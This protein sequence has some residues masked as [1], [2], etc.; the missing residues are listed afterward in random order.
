MD[1]QTFEVKR[2]Y[3]DPAYRRKGVASAIIT[4]L[5]RDAA[6]HG[7]TRAILETARTTADSRRALRKAR[8]SGHRLL[9]QSRRCGKLPVL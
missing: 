6:A 8:L 7:Y 9:R 3:I 5:E 2:I 1:E 4:A